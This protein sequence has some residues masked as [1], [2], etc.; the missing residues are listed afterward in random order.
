MTTTWILLITDSQTGEDVDAFT[1]PTEVKARAE[2]L[3][4]QS[5]FHR[6]TVREI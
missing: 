1:F 4:W 2:A 5:R 3:K 6:I